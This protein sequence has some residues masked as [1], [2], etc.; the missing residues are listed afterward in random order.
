[1]DT[2]EVK[3]TILFFKKRTNRKDL[4]IVQVYLDDIIFESTNSL[5]TKEFVEIMSGEF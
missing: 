4:F 2:Q 3:T 1:M 5:I